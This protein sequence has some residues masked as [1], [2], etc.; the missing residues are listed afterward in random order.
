[1]AAQDYTESPSEKTY[2]ESTPAKQPSP[3]AEPVSPPVSLAAPPPEAPLPG[4]QCEEQLEPTSLPPAQS[5][6][7][8]TPENSML[9]GK[10]LPPTPQYSAPHALR[11]SNSDPSVSEEQPPGRPNYEAFAAMNYGLGLP[12]PLPVPGIS[13]N[14]ATPFNQHKGANRSSRSFRSAAAAAVARLTN[15]VTPPSAQP[16]PGA[17]P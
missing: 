15:Q 10:A 8:P 4:P 14:P 3:K 6:L 17:T 16:T 12:G 2:A 11:R 1:M 13:S 7:P 5:P 9:Y